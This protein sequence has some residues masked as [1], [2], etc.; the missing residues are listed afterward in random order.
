[1]DAAPELTRMTWVDE[2]DSSSWAFVAKH[3]GAS[4]TRFIVCVTLKI[5]EL[6]IFVEFL[7]AKLAER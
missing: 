1:M 3:E 2:N 5:S 4:G 6:D 7:Y